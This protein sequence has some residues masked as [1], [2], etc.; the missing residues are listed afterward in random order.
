MTDAPVAA[1]AVPRS[2]PALGWALRTLQVETAGVDAALADLDAFV[3]AYRVQGDSIEA[4][5]EAA[6][7]AVRHAVDRLRRL[8]SAYGE[9][10]PFDAAAYFDFSQPQ[11][12]HLVQVTERVTSVHVTLHADLLLPSFRRA[13]ATWARVFLPAWLRLHE[14]GEAHETLLLQGQPLLVEHLREAEAVI[15]KTRRLLLADIG[16]LVANG[17]DEER[18]RWSST[19]VPSPMFDRN[20]ILDPQKTPTL[21]LIA[22]FPHPVARQPGR[23]RR[24]RR[25]RARQTWSAT[26]RSRRGRPHGSAPGSALD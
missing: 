2:L 25:H 15:T 19:G 9:W 18:W 8:A 22:D 23:L 11:A 10:N 20:L 7:H 5:A 13:V 1:G 17:A 24:L 12:D 14:S 21:T 16:Y 4:E 3:Q 6:A 26:R